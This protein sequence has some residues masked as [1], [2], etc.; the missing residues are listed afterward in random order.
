MGSASLSSIFVN[1]QLFWKIESENGSVCIRTPE[2]PAGRCRPARVTTRVRRIPVSVEAPWKA[3]LG[4]EERSE[5]REKP[6]AQTRLSDITRQTRHTLRSPALL[7]SAEFPLALARLRTLSFP[8]S[9]LLLPSVKFSYITGTTFHPN[10]AVG[11][12][13]FAL[14]CLQFWNLTFLAD[15]CVLLARA[16]CWRGEVSQLCRICLLGSSSAVKMF[17]QS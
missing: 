12:F 16:S 4:G 1:M 13:L 8:I 15:P 14:I 10:P 17:I 3:E 6:V 5:S 7:R 11:C 2:S 9:A